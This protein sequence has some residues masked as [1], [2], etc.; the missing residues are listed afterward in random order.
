VNAIF[1]TRLA[2]AT[3]ASESWLKDVFGNY[4]HAAIRLGGEPDDDCRRHRD[5]LHE[6]ALALPGFEKSSRVTG[7][8]DRLIDLSVKGKIT[9]ERDD[10][11]DRRLA[12]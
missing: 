2:C 4:P 5:D 12:G 6:R 11:R 1:C 7:E 3:P 10:H 8:R 9:E